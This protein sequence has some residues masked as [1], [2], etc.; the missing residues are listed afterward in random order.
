VGKTRSEEEQ[1]VANGV[2]PP[3]IR[4]AGG[5]LWRA[6]DRA[7]AVAN[8]EVALIHRPRYDDWSFP[9]GKLSSG[10]GDVDGAV[11]EVL[12]ETGF[13]VRVGRPLGEVRYMKASG[14]TSRP[15]V[16]RYWAMEAD[17][18]SFSPN[19]EVDELRWVSL[20]EAETMLTH[21]HDHEL[22]RRFVSGPALTGCVLLVRH[23]SAGNRSEWNGDDKRRPLDQ[24][25]WGQAEDLV[26]LLTRFEVEGIVS[27]D[28][29][30][31]VQTVQPLSEAV[32]IP[33]DEDD[34]FSEL[35]YPAHEEEATHMIRKLG[36]SLSTTVI[37][38]QG[39]VIPDLLER[40]AAEDN[41]D[42]PDPLPKKKGSTWALIF[43]GPRLFSA[44]YF[45]PSSD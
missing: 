5:V 30:R 21:D 16:V 22:L 3:V 36:E 39:D 42:L 38:S 25:G 40:L 27:A 24:D 31:C 32:G 18:G 45:P 9:K 34:L 35:G 1:K 4:A 29:D 37:C 44:E 2:R 43:D 8:V 17:G 28:F 26:R 11:R 33:I 14:G 12:E 15:K 41:V 23:A 7:S 13:R 6:I 10:E 19:R 20:G